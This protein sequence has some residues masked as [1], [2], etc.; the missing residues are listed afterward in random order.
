MDRSLQQF[1]YGFYINPS[2]MSQMP[3]KE[4]EKKLRSYNVSDIENKGRTRR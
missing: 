3:R 4:N 2:I 1:Y